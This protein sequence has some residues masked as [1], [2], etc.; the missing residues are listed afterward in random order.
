MDSGVV[1]LG[2]K[3]QLSVPREIMERLGLRGGE[4][5][6]LEVT[7]EGEIVLHPAGVYPLEVYG[8]SRVKE[9]LNADRL[10]DDEKEKLARVVA[11]DEP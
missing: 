2:K 5:L 3:G 11:R 10:S 1:R 7:D 8:D 9:F 6:V 4:M